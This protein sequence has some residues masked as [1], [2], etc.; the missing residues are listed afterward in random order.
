MDIAQRNWHKYNCLLRISC[1]FSCPSTEKP[2]QQ[3]RV[4]LH[5]WREC[6]LKNWSQVE[7]QK[8]VWVPCNFEL[9]TF[10]FCGKRLCQWNCREFVSMQLLIEGSYVRR[11]MHAQTSSIQSTQSGDK[12]KNWKFWACWMNHYLSHVWYDC[13][14]FWISFLNMAHHIKKFVWIGIFP[15]WLKSEIKYCLYG[16]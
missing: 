10:Q 3:K 14:F 13:W 8:K 7:E 11:I 12:V 6:V 15:P 4:I 16:T 2:C 5:E 1:I 9:Q